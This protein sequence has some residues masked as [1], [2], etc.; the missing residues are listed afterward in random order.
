MRALVILAAA[1]CAASPAVSQTV[2]TYDV[3]R[4]AAPPAIDGVVSPG[5]WDAAGAPA[6]GWGELQQ[7][8]PPDAD[9]AGNRFRMLWDD[10]ALYL[11]YQT[12]QTLWAPAPAESNPLFDFVTDQLYLYLD[13]NADSEPN[14]R[15]NPDE[16]PDHYE[17]ALNQV[18]GRRVSTDANRRGVGI[19]TEA[20]VDSL[21]GDLADWNQGADPLSG[22]ALGGAVVAQDNGAAGGLAELR[23]PWSMFDAPPTYRGPN[24]RGDYTADGEVDASD[25]TRWRDT[26]GQGVVAP[27]SGADGNENGAVDPADRQVWSAAYGQSGTVATGLFHPFA[28]TPGDVWYFNIG[29]VSNADPLNVLP[30]YNWTESFFFAA[31]PHAE[32]TFVGGSPA[33]AVPEPTGWAGFLLGCAAFC[34]RRR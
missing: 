10:S 6:G 7:F 1:Q 15:S 16:S 3:N 32:I 34:W 26:L 22:A 33:V 4:A 14:F 18:S 25:Y 30:V 11:L 20:R 5:E 29:Q 31:R 2:R 8:S 24:P 13:P 27:G 28:P 9:T 23:L 21:F 12:N 19:S 17:L